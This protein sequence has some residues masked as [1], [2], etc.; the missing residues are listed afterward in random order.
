MDPTDKPRLRLDSLGLRRHRPTASGG[1]GTT[2][3]SAGPLTPPEPATGGFWRSIVTKKGEDVKEIRG[4]THEPVHLPASSQ[5]TAQAA[6]G[7]TRQMHDRPP[8]FPQHP[9]SQPFPQTRD[10]SDNEDPDNDPDTRHTIAAL[11]AQLRTLRTEHDGLRARLDAAA[12]D[13][14][15]LLKHYAM[16]VRDA[17]AEKHMQRRRANALED[18]VARLKAELEGYRRR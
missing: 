1:S 9:P 5:A 14:A 8:P 6:H 15:G 4:V 11:R 16:E 13:N 7:S 18:E 2:L 10:S 3:S 12:A 17:V